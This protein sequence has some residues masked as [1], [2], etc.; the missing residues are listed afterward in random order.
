[1]PLYANHWV[2]FE[3]KQR[4]QPIDVEVATGG[5]SYGAAQLYVGAT[6]GC[7]KHLASMNL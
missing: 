7:D 3:L 5:R 1:M 6:F 4:L 2:E